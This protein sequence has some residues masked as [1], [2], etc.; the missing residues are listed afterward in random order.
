[1]LR[2]RVIIAICWMM[3]TNNHH[4]HHDGTSPLRPPPHEEVP[5]THNSNESLPRCCVRSMISCPRRWDRQYPHQQQQQQQQHH[6]YHHSNNSNSN[7][8]NSNKHNTAWRRCNSSYD[9]FSCNTG[10]PH[11]SNSTHCAYEKQGQ[12]HSNQR[13]NKGKPRKRKRRTPLLRPR[14]I[15][16]SFKI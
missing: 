13:T 1:M 12:R 3:I 10:D 11:L 2:L 15:H 5:V 16:H 6:H 8:H 14:S 9:G 4:H 7:K